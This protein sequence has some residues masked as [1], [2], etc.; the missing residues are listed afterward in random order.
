MNNIRHTLLIKQKLFFFLEELKKYHAVVRDN[1]TLENV[2]QNPFSKTV[3]L[4]LCYGNKKN[5]LKEDC[6][7]NDACKF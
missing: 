7:F 2:T 4:K 3:I 6:D 1:L 5:I